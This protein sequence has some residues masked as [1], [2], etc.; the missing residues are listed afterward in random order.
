MRCGH[1]LRIF[2]PCAV[3]VVHVP[4]VCP[5]WMYICVAKPQMLKTDVLAV[6]SWHWCYC[7]HVYAKSQRSW[8]S[9]FFPSPLPSPRSSH[10]L[11]AGHSVQFTHS[12]R[13]HV[14]VWLHIYSRLG[15][16]KGN[17][18]Y[19]VW[20]S[21]EEL[22]TS[23]PT[24][25]HASKSNWGNWLDRWVLHLPFSMC[26]GWRCLPRGWLLTE[27][28][29]SQLLILTTPGS[30]ST[31]RLDQCPLKDWRLINVSLVLLP[32]GHCHMFPLACEI[33]VTA[34]P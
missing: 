34:F 15:G 11:H 28:P 1:L 19:M 7:T 14:C 24:L 16:M 17:S 22:E 9:L 10:G 31:T 25:L 20:A 2:P 6:R 13:Q 18:G 33:S 3:A 12:Q 32:G 26:A 8:H 23:G 27:H 30:M 5:H 4:V 29:C 21:V